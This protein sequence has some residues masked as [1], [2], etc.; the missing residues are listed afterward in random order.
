MLF[1]QIMKDDEVGPLIREHGIQFFVEDGNKNNPDI[2]AVYE[3]WR[4]DKGFGLRDILRGLSFVPKS[5]SR[6]IQFADF[7]AFFS[8]RHNEKCVA[9]GGPLP[10]LPPYLQ[11]AL[12]RIRHI[13][14]VANDFFG[15]DP[16]ERGGQQT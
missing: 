8:R 4:N 14:F 5:S 10:V 15:A 7:A 2:A 12:S 1:D 11:K 9:A 3:R 16:S 13:S 6:A